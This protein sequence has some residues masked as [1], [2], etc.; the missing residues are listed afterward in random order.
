MGKLME[1]GIIK[2]L[3]CAAVPKE[4]KE[5]QAK[6]DTFLGLLRSF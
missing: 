5:Y 2:H 4:I 1:V 6:M 3:L